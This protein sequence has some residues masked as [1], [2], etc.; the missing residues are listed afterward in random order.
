MDNS[1]YAKVLGE[2]AALLQIKGA[3]RFKVRP[4]PS[5]HLEQVLVP[6]NGSS[7]MG[8]QQ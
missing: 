1:Y 3:N 2:V 7:S 8:R 4:S 6:A 5:L